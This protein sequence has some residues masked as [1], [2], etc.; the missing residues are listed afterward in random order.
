[1]KKYCYCNC[2][3]FI[4]L[5]SFTAVAQ[6]VEIEKKLVKKHLYTL[7]SDKM[8]GRLVGT[9]GIELAAQYIEG[10]FLR[11]GL[12]TFQGAS[13][14]RQTFHKS[15]IEM[16]NI[17]GVLKGTSLKDEWVVVSA[18]Y[19]HLG[20]LKAVKGDSIANGA[21]DDASGVTAVLTLANYFKNKGPFKR[22]IVFIAFT[23]E[24]KGLWGSTYF[25]TQVNADKCIAGINIEMIGKDS[26]FGPKTA[27]LTG[28]ERSDFG[29]IIQKNLKGTDYTLHPDPYKK[30]N[31]FY[32]SDNASLARLGVPAH[33]FS[34]CPI[35]KDLYYHTV[36]DEVETL[37]V[38]TI[39][40]TIKA[41][42]IGTE[43]IIDGVDTPT[44]VSVE[45]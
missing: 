28:F 29:K 22:S 5:L 17:I 3:V 25:G 11:L 20:I 32:R 9:E 39:A 26:K 1:M 42:A 44:R 14:Y 34:T 18:H 35:D 38:S 41:I 13:D 43:S 12:E 6:Q 31:L 7:A 21:D 37:E 19:D 8:E 45:K 40:N 16:S 10:E 4:V 27:F 15:G 36:D 23:G 33:T 30:F 24:E 2:L